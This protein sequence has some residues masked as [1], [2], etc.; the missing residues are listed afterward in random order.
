MLTFS[1]SFIVV[2]LGRLCKVDM[3]C[4]SA[5]PR[6]L[7]IIID[8]VNGLYTVVVGGQR[9]QDIQV[10]VNELQYNNTIRG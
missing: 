2:F 5:L 6:Q 9:R 8:I 4:K 7:A 10:I 1:N 3:Y